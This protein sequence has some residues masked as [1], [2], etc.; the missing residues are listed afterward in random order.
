MFKHAKN[1]LPSNFANFFTYNKN[2]HNYPTRTCNYIHLNNPRLLIAQKALR[3]H[4]PDVWN[5]L[6]TCVK[7]KSFLNPFKKILKQTL[8][9]KYDK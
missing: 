4:G 3:H 7:E 2:I 9:N 1:V 8:V 6:P 5:N